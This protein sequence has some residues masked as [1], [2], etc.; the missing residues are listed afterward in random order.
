MRKLARVGLGL[1][2]VATPIAAAGWFAL[3]T[4]SDLPDVSS[5]HAYRPPVVTT[6]WSRDGVLMAELFAERRR[7]VDVATLPPH[8]TRAFLAAEDSQFFHHQGLNWRGIL[9]AAWANL[10]EQRVAQGGSTI[11]Q[12]VVKS[13]LLS[14]ER[15]FRRKLREA[16]LAVRI[17]GNLTKDEILHLYLNQ[18]YLGHGAH[19]VEAASE[20]YFGT[21]SQK[22]S[23][24]QAALLAGL[25]QAPSRYDPYQQ[26]ERARER[27]RYVLTRMAEEGWAT[28]EEA[29]RA[30]AEPLGLVGYQNPFLGVSPYFSEHV[31]RLL[32]GRYGRETLLTGGL[33]VATT[34]DARLQ[35]AA[36]RALRK[37]IEDLDRSSGFRGALERVDPAAP[38]PFA[39]GPPPVGG[40]RSRAVVVATDAAGA[41]VLAGG[42]RIRLP[43]EGMAWAFG[44]RPRSTRGLTPGDVV[45]C[46]FAESPG[47]GLTARLA[48][49][50]QVE[51]ALVCLDPRTGEVLA[52]VGGYDF[53]RSQ[54]NRAVQAFRQPGSALKPMIF[55]AAVEQGY[56][57]ATLVYDT[58]IVYG[59]QDPEEETW[60]PK[61]Y[62][63]QFYGATTLRDALVHSRNIVTVKILRDVGV[64]RALQLLQ[65]LGITSPM[66]PDLSLALG[67]SAVTP[68]E[69]VSAYGS[70][71]TGGLRSPP[72]FLLRVQDR[73]GAILEEFTPPEPQR[74][75]RADIAYVLTHMMQAV[76]TE[77]TARR[78]A[79][80]GVPAAG[81]TGTTNDNRDAWFVGYTPDLV[82]G[83][84]LGH[85]SGASLGKGET[86]GRIAAPIWLD[87][88]KE[89]VQGRPGADFPVPEGVEFARIDGAGRLARSAGSE[90]AT[91]AFRKGTAPVSTAALPG[92]EE[93]NA[94]TLDPRDPGT[95]DALR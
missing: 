2:V 25:P 78:A 40:R 58:A 41:W 17:E 70:F 3:A 27:R 87:F 19:G 74:A 88:M 35:G 34:M 82:A 31:R 22:L 59:S 13:L 49:E 39:E 8:V 91:V 15:S 12:Q 36:Q 21:S 53:G 61:N 50:P 75:L 5:L 14:P 62:S 93:V 56:T 92:D 18:I 76:L 68:L 51:G 79:S 60:K 65:E 57:P 11:T 32:E 64:P 29:A 55:A 77:G 48:Q 20:T 63:A 46:D 10:R 45:W 38:G 85:D 30:A 54:F 1:L 43:A 28:R 83:V 66:S 6:V 23:L 84:W 9:R 26:P 42:R 37:G 90:T 47:G 89:A 16:V 80:L 94:A 24:A 33:R 44:D 69:L 72:A 52:A 67:A 86:G 73:D 7:V 71:A 4:L 81:K 95:L